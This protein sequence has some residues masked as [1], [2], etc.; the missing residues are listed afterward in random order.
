MAAGLLRDWRRGV[1]GIGGPD[2]PNRRFDL[3][4]G[5]GVKRVLRP[6]GGGQER[7]DE[8]GSDHSAPKIQYQR[9]TTAV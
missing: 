7:G 8:E 3:R 5:E 2:D 1:I 6:D 9:V 4:R